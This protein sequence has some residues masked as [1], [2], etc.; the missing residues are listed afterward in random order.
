MH[1][2][3]FLARKSEPCGHRHHERR[4]GMERVTYYSESTIPG[5]FRNRAFVY[6]KR[7]RAFYEQH[8]GL[9]VELHHPPAAPETYKAVIEKMYVE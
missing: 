9:G 3:I 8:G 5:I 4:V 7:G 2:I 1:D 6:S